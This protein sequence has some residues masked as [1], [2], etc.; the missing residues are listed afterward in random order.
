MYGQG[1]LKGLRVTFRHFFGKALTEQYP[2]RYPQLPPRSHGS[3][4]LEAGKCTGCGT[5]ALSCP[6]K[7]ISVDTF[8]DEN[9]KRHV[10]GFK[11]ELMYCLFC[12]LCVESCPSNALKFTTDFELSS[13]SRDDTILKLYDSLPQE[14]DKANAQ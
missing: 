7:V 1:L 14:E 8:R 5:C 3:F 4:E 12:G 9:K 10:T 11:M 6:N 2:E 13:Y